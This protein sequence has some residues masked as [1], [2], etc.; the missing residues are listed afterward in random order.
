[1]LVTLA[2]GIR[3]QTY[4][5]GTTPS[6]SR[7]ADPPSADA[8]SA[9]LSSTGPPP[10]DPSSTELPSTVL[11]S[12]VPPPVD[13]LPVVL[14]HGGPG[15]WD[16]LAPLAD[17]ID[18]RVVHRYDQRGCGG[19]DP[20]DEQSI[21]RLVA[22]LEELR[23]HWG[24]ERMVVVGH[25]FGAT[26]ALRYAAA[27]PTRVAHLIYLSGV[28]V[29]DWLTPSLAEQRRR[30]TT[31]QAERLETLGNRRPRTADEE[32]EF[33]ALSWFTDHADRERAWAWAL[34][35]AAVPWPINFAANNALTADNRAFGDDRLIEL[36]RTLAMPVDFVHAEGDPRPASAVRKLAD[37][38]PHAEFHLVEGAGHSPWRER[39]EEFRLLLQRILSAAG[40]SQ[41]D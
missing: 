22:D 19:S 23:E 3:L 12:T 41:R 20:S 7:P 15:L 10:V 30:M 39:P 31:E 4:T 1:M 26:L 14:L 5:S 13:P 37:A 29:G 25:S 18:D 38:V 16:Y 17:L 27:H 32:R 34:E 9:E 24:H 35:D 11:S 33:R 21:A 8:P 2:D 28:G 40:D 36:A 6:A